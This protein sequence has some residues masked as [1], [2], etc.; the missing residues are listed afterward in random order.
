MRCMCDLWE[1]K[2]AIIVLDVVKRALKGLG[3]R[4]E[5]C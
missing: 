3:E 4:R 2:M 5:V 1:E